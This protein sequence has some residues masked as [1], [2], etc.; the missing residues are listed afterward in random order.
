ML[1]CEF[2][3]SASGHL[4]V[5]Q[6]QPLTWEDAL[7]SSHEGSG[8]RAQHCN[9]CLLGVMGPYS[10][11]W[12]SC[13]QRVPL[14]VSCCLTGHVAW[15][16]LEEGTLFTLPASGPP[17]PVCCRTSQLPSGGEGPALPGAAAGVE[18]GPRL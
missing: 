13:P 11:T 17:C 4:F 10:C 8:L 5:S 14:G 3:V 15:K 12:P 2:A 9:Q 18:R 16:E 7:M 1:L 6:A